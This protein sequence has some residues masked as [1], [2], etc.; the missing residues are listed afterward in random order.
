MEFDLHLEA[1]PGAH[2]LRSSWVRV[3]EECGREQDTERER[4]TEIYRER[5]ETD[6]E[7]TNMLEPI[8]GGWEVV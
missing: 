2:R 7:S 5:G 8:R 1:P 3:R 6:S 4:D